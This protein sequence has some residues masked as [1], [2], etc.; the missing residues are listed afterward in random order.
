VF[1][2]DKKH[3]ERMAPML[4]RIVIGDPQAAQARVIG[5][6]MRDMMRSEIH[7]ATSPEQVME[8][9]ADKDPQLLF[10]ERTDRFDGVALTR[11]IRRS[12]LSC[13]KAPVILT[14]ATATAAGILQARDAGVHEFLLKPFTIK[15]LTRRL[16]AVAVRQRDWIEA[17]NYV[18]PDRRR[19]N[20]GD[21][22][23]PLKRRSD[24]Q[25]PERQRVSQ[26]IKIL[27]SSLGAFDSDPDQ[28]LRSIESQLADIHQAATAAGDTKLAAMAQQ[29]A[30][31]IMR[32]KAS[33]QRLSAAELEQRAAPVLA[34]APKEPGAV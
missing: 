26:A 34:F 7:I 27:K 33:G 32:A 15:D 2:A 12:S 13:R 16:E 31:H 10:L 11:K 21:Y 17:V 20:S 1:E 18:G 22:T 23:G 14:T 30:M 6:M 25:T 29:L 19:F 4:H 24:R 9:A 5:Q 28:A 8:L 3:I